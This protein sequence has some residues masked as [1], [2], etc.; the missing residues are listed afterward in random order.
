MFKNKLSLFKKFSGFLDFQKSRNN[1][2][3]LK[4]FF[5]LALTL[6]PAIT[7]AAAPVEDLSQGGYAPEPAPQNNNGSQQAIPVIDSSALAIP[8]RL[9]RVEQQI[10]NLVQMNMP[11]QVADLQMQVQ[12]LTGQLQ[13]LNHQ[14][15]LASQ[16]QQRV[17]ALPATPPKLE[18]PPNQAIITANK[19]PP[20]D[21][22]PS[23]A[24]PPKTDASAYELAFTLLSNKQ[25]DEAAVAFKDYLLK[26]PDGQF[27]ANAHFWLGDIYFQQKNLSQAEL[28]FNLITAQYA[29]SGKAPDA[30][31]KLATIHAQQGK[32]S[33]ARE[34]LKN[35]MTRYPGSSAAQLASVQLQQLNANSQ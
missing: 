31:L 20:S 21:A 34:E 4:L 30:Q 24:T 19:A 12:K 32:T 25:Y 23:A 14:M 27:V 1:S 11:Q 7:M 28:E 10:N 8:D 35:I 22:A 16:Q 9:T 15:D 5:A 13:E 6:A 33:Q 29:A 2:F 3:S 18:T 26:H 17:E